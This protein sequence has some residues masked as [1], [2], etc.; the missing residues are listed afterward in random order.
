MMQRVRN[1]FKQ[2]SFETQSK[3][4]GSKIVEADELYINP[5]PSNMHT[6]RRIKY[7]EDGKPNRIVIAGAIERK[8]EVRVTKVQKASV[9][10]LVPF[11][12]KNVVPGSNL[13]T[14]EHMSYEKLHRIFDHNTVKH[15]LKE[16]VRIEESGR[17]VS[18][19]AIENFWSVLI[20]ALAG[21]YHQIS[22]K[23]CQ[24]YL[25]EF[26]FRFNS[27]D[28]TEAQRFDK[29]ISLSNYR[30]DYATLTETKKVRK[31]KKD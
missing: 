18:T 30:I 24:N 23:H 8:G 14:D 9:N 28:Y 11:L 1:A 7:E 12:I 13:M 16:Y 5:V 31:A 20:R 6:K 19:N 2:H 22:G 29:L 17:R 15:A 21:T 3:I 25:E 10:E 4:G 27:R 26:A